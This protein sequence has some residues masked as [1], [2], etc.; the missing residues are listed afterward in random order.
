MLSANNALHLTAIPLR[1]IAAGELG[2]SAK[3]AEKVMLRRLI[4]TL[5]SD[6]RRLHLEEV[7]GHL[8]IHH[9]LSVVL[10][11]SAAHP[12][13]PWG[14]KAWSASQGRGHSKD[15]VIAF[16]L[17]YLDATGSRSRG[18]PRTIRIGLAKPDSVMSLSECTA[19]SD[20]GTSFDWSKLHD[21]SES[22]LIVTGF[23]S[24][25]V[26]YGGAVELGRI[27]VVRVSD[28]EYRACYS[29]YSS[30]CDICDV[31][32]SWR[33]SSSYSS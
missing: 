4:K 9:D 27:S 8:E 11:H 29:Y 31:D 30:I 19:E 6:S 18:N 10:D 15:D 13:D 33:C 25:R 23:Y 26:G 1:S 16:I 20:D 14:S 22:C 2:R 12:D 21:R 7:L 28:T 32:R 24:P 5:F 17:E 3:E